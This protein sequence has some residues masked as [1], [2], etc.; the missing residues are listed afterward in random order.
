ML[1]IAPSGPPL[2]PSQIERSAGALPAAPSAPPSAT[3]KSDTRVEWAGA[4]RPADPVRRAAHATL[5]PAA[6]MR[7]DPDRPTGPPPAFAAN[8]LDVLKEGREPRLDDLIPDP[9][10]VAQQDSGAQASLAAQAVPLPQQ[11]TET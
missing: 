10:G 2:W 7:S 3:T 4:V 5:T 6:P 9:A 11:A 8:I 1:T